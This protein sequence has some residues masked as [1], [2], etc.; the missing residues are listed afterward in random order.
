MKKTN[1]IIAKRVKVTSGKK[2]KIMRKVS[3]Q[4]HYNANDTGEERRGKK[5]MVCF[6]KTA[7]KKLK[8]LI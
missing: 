2:L 8:S 6:N 5:G 7:A 4:S 3:K 1:K